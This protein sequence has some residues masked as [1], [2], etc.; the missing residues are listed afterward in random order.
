M[1]VKGSDT[2]HPKVEGSSPLDEMCRFRSRV[3]CNVS[4]CKPFWENI[5]NKNNKNSQIHE[6]GYSE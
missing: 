2:P 1:G 4:V 6:N 3:M 5:L